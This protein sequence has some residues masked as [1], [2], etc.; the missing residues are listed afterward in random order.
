MVD[1][2]MLQDISYVRL[3]VPDAELVNEEK[4]SRYYIRHSLSHYEMSSKVRTAKTA[5]KLARAWVDEIIE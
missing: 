4:T 1:E 5:W 2:E 3:F